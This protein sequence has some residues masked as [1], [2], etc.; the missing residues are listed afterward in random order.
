MAIVQTLI[1]NVKGPK[2]DTGAT[3]QTGAA[4]ADG[5]AATIEVGTVTTVSY[6]TPASVTNSGTESAAVFDFQLPQGPAGATVTDMSPLLLN[7]VTAS[8][9][10]FPSPAVGES[11]ATIFGKIIKFFSDVVSALNGK[12]NTS[13]IANNLTTNTAGYVLDARQGYAIGQA[14]ATT[15]ASP[16]P[17]LSLGGASPSETYLKKCANVVMFD[18]AFSLN[19]TEAA[20]L[21]GVDTIGT[22]PTG[23][24]P[25]CNVVI[26]VEARSGGTWAEATYYHAIIL[27]N[28]S[29]GQIS[30]RGGASNLQAC[31]N[32]NLHGTWLT[33]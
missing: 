26:P 28:S 21:T 2:G 24:R 4:G 12:V 29:N 18:A 14:L 6:G 5:A 8:T 20:T 22:I 25:A 11:G 33:A 3:G 15:S 32:F 7:S 1:G 23:F 27:V 31:R 17:T 30:V 16:V 10:S 9:A 13:A 19:A